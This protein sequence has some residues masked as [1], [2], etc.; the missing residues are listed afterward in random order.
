[1][2]VLEMAEPKGKSFESCCA[3]TFAPLTWFP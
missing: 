2:M 1:M 3:V